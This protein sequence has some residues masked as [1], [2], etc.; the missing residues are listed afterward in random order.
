MM[1]FLKKF[2]I[3]PLEESQKGRLEYFLK[4]L[5]VKPLQETISEG[6]C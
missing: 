2:G 6:S 5:L 3:E 4:E 1:D